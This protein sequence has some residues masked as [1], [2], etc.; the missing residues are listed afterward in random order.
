MTRPTMPLQDQPARDAIA[1]DF[2]TTYVVEAA[3]GTGKT[4]A[5]VARIVGLLAGGTTE[6]ERVVSVTFTEKAAGEMKL[7]V[8]SKIEEE[9]KTSSGQRLER[10]DRALLQLETARIGTIH[11]L[12]ADI[13]RE[14]P[15]E[16]NI[17]PVF[18][19]S[20]EPES[21]DRYRRVFDAWYLRKLQSPGDG[22]R[23]ILRRIGSPKSSNVR[24][25]LQSA[26]WEICEHRDF[27]GVW[28]VPGFKR[29]ALVDSL[30]DGMRPL[31][32][33]SELAD[34]DYN[35]FAKL[36][37]E[38]NR[39]LRRIDRLE[40]VHPRD[41]DG[42]ELDLLRFNRR[43][44][45]W[46]HLNTKPWRGQ[47]GSGISNE[48]V[49]KRRD[50]WSDELRSFAA[51]AE[52][53]L[54]PMLHAELRPLV[55]LYTAAMREVGVLDFVDLLQRTRD[56]L[57]DS[58]SVRRELQERFSHI[59]IDEFQDTDPLQADIARLLASD[60]PT[61]SDPDKVRT[62][63]G[64]LFIVGDPKQS[65]YRFRRADLAI[66]K[67]IKSQ[68]CATG[69]Q[70]LHLSVSFR[71]DPRIQA[72]VNGAFASLMEGG[73]QADYVP[74]MPHRD[75][76]PGRP[77]LVALPPP[78]PYTLY[79]PDWKKTAYLTKK[80]FAESA[81][82]AVG[83]F[84]DF[85]V[86]ESGW[87]VT[88]PESGELVPIRPRHICLLF[89][90][91][92]G[93]RASK[94]TPFV[95]ELE[96][97]EIPHVLIGGGSFH[98]RE[99]VM[100]MRN[101]LAAIERPEDSLS[102]YAALRGPLF[103]LGDDAL[104]AWKTQFGSL[105]PLAPVD[106]EH[107]VG[108]LP[109]VAEGL[110]VLREL[111]LRRNRRHFDQ[112]VGELLERTRAHAGLAIW[113]AGEQVLANVLRFVD[114]ARESEEGGARSFR[115][116]V[117][118]LERDAAAGSDPSAPSLEEGTEGVRMMTVHKSK[119]L[120]FPVVILCD[121]EA[122]KTRQR[123]SRLLDT[124]RRCW[125]KS[126]AG[127]SPAELQGEADE[128]LQLEAEES[129][130]ALYVAATR[131]RDLL[132]IPASGDGR[133]SR[134]DPHSSWMSPLDPALFP[135]FGEHRNSER[136]P[137]CPRL[138]EDT[139]NVRHVAMPPRERTVRPGLHRSQRGG[140]VV[141]WSAAGLAPPRTKPHGLRHQEL[142]IGEDSA[143][144]SARVRAAHESWVAGRQ[145]SARLGRLDA[146]SVRTATEEA[147]SE[148]AE[149]PEL[150]PCVETSAAGRPDRPRGIRFGSIVHGVLEWVPYD[151][152]VDVEPFVRHQ[153]RLLGG[154]ERDVAAGIEAVRAA[155]D[156]P[157]LRRAAGSPD[158]RREATFVH[159]A[160]E[161]TFVEGTIDLVF[162]EDV[163]AEDGAMKERWIVV[164]FKTGRGDEETQRRYGI[165]LGIYVEAVRAATGAE[166][167][168]TLLI[169]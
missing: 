136:A 151:A 107:L 89:R 169:V 106:E 116:F 118:R 115:G 69:A 43:W 126:I 62:I 102:V 23:R 122:A 111:H 139:L 6:L 109:E 68:L 156:H 165:Q 58:E 93:H 144:P 21:F 78:D 33:L 110:T 91:M 41:Y 81:P 37:A 77:A 96:I 8:R 141:W 159:Q 12:C 16:A 53:Q 35:P 137:G 27:D 29:E 54:A 22:I 39:E 52:A 34:R 84:V 104:L 7:R 18:R 20:P 95:R 80:A 32:S 158:C 47:F 45:N 42:L 26:G 124:E 145:R 55:G 132:V 67:R 60:D 164:E 142:L 117:E 50:A 113:N 130:R 162:R 114:L 64:K 36:G 17:D 19:V 46:K 66:Y 14:R 76:V 83:S 90:S 56:L 30:I 128:V 65:V 148:V 71:S 9:R 112:T 149:L 4:S 163:P 82:V 70:E 40:L 125:F 88:D 57:V 97:R 38:M 28:P 119:G 131:A 100:A 49:A 157:L 75:P 133:L 1:S 138:G 63:P 79:G 152:D 168:G 108:I 99:E 161:G 121:P 123:P 51:A 105:H 48:D 44:D 127:C 72:L 13:L 59:L 140:E 11:S 61:E 147:R 74:L 2:G 98:D 86:N 73:S 134:D 15:V 103:A 120:E 154:D 24:S 94:T 160:S 5:L 143:S 150:P 85:L 146:I 10:L 3:A 92:R 155:I 129:D 31:A 135:R 25:Q 153:A 87:T 167:D 166:V 101:V